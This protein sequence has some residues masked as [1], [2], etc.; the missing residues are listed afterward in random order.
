MYDFDNDGDIDH[1]DAAG[2]YSAQ[3]DTLAAQGNYYLAGQYADI[4]ASA[5]ALGAFIDVFQGD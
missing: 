5:G 2:I 1:T 3:S 4:G